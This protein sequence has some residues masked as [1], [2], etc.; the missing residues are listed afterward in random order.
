[1]PK[2]PRAVLKEYFQTGDQ[3]TAQQFS[4]TL[5]SVV[6]FVDDRDFIGLRNYN[7]ALNYLPTDCA[8]FGNQVVQCITATTGP[9]NPA[10]WQVISSVGSVTYVS[11]WDTQSNTPPLQSS[12]G[13]K[14]FYYVVTNASSDPNDNTELDGI[15]DWGTGDWAIFNGS[16]WQKVDNSNAPVI[17]QNVSFEPTG[18]ISAINV[19]DAIKELDTEKQQMISVKPPYI[20]YAFTTNKLAESWLAHTENGIIVSFRKIIRSE[21]PGRAQI[22]FGNAGDEI[23]LSTAGFN[24]VESRLLLNGKELNAFA[25]SI[26]AIANDTKSGMVIQD[27][28]LVSIYNDGGSGSDAE[29]NL[30]P[31]KLKL[32]QS[33]HANVLLDAGT[34]TQGRVKLSAAGN[35]IVITKNRIR[36][37]T[38][39]DASVLRVGADGE[40]E[41]SSDL[42]KINSGEVFVDSVNASS[43]VVTDANQVLTASTVT[44]T[45]LESLSGITSSVQSQLDAK[46]DLAG[47][48]MNG[49]LILDAD[50]VVSLGAATKGYTDGG[51]AQK[52][53]LAGGTLTGPLTLSADPVTALQAAT[54]QYVDNA[55]AGLQTQINAKVNLAGD[56]MTGDLIL[57][58]DPTVSLG[59]AT[60]SYTDTGLGTKVSK[61]G[62]T[63]TGSLVLSGN[64][65]TALEAATKQY[66][67]NADAGL[68]TQVNA[69]VNRAG[70]T[71]TGSLILNADPVTALEAVTKQYMDAALT[72][73]LDLSGGTMTGSLELSAD[74]SLP[75][76][77]ATKQ[78]VDLGD[79]S[80]LAQVNT[81]V[82]RSGD[83]MT[84]DLILNA[85]PVVSLG[86]A[87][88]SYTDSGLATKVSKSGDTMTGALV[89][90]ADPVTALGAATKQYVNNEDAVLQTQIN[91]KVNRS[92][93]TMTGFLVL[94]A[95]PL[96]ALGAV[97]RQYADAIQTA[98]NL[99]ISAKV[100]KSGD[101]MTGALILNADPSAALGAAT[102][103][104]VDAATKKLL[105]PF[106]FDSDYITSS[107]T[108]TSIPLQITIP[109]P[110]AVFAGATTVTAKLTIDY[111]VENGSTPAVGEAGL[112]EWTSATSGSP[113]LIAGSSLGMTGTP[114]TWIK[115]TSTTAFA[116]AGDRSYRVIFR[117]TTG[118]GGSR[119]RIES[120]CLTLYYS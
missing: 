26:K 86:A 69:K 94:N 12:V 42:L 82:N 34:D 54:M 35:D 59:A 47:G 36:L 29:I 113:V 51:L 74:P 106:T 31:G 5:D 14:G 88:K 52:L 28:G 41:I 57:N 103:Q 81:K 84:G 45:E 1:M 101:T 66:V 27:E 108:F 98:A 87:T 58:A 70:D 33:N 23:K 111:L 60:K 61:T 43:V 62:D 9:F 50:P 79:M 100:S 63:M 77:A 17:A 105:V 3:P 115:A 75:L 53:D 80:L 39:S 67:D 78:Y 22:D 55:D 7:P 83:T 107:A 99:A 117:K 8:V 25:H 2:V 73:K 24:P 93:D 104:Y 112:T 95:D 19:Q 96:T 4:T 68:Q 90:N 38:D 91:A 72:A 110:A 44:T 119:V 71:M 40:V 46:L 30:E 116:V 56:T 15:D 20:P 118:S 114:D 120:A 32:S 85:D 109:A 37:G 64:P 89:L 97:T 48:T 102:K 13:T 10:H 92:G 6:N 16:V 18:N 65:V 49:A 21:A 11:A 76:G